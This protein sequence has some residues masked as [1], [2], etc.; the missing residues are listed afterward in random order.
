MSDDT[1][2]L[3]I[4]WID[5]ESKGYIDVF[6]ASIFFNEGTI[7]DY[8]HLVVGPQRGRYLAKCR[9]VVDAVSA[10]LDY[11][12]FPKQNK[13]R[14]MLLGVLRL[15]FE[16]S[17]REKLRAIEWKR[18]GQKI[19]TSGLAEIVNEP[20]KIWAKY[21]RKAADARKVVRKI[22][23]REGAALFRAELMLAYN[24]QCCVSGCAIAA[25]L[26][27]AHIDPFYGKSSDNPQN[28]LLL[29]R[30]LHALFDADLLAVEPNSGVVHIAPEAQ[31]SPEYKVL[32]LRK[33]TLPPSS[34][35]PSRDAL[36]RR[37]FRFKRVNPPVTT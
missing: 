29:R 19:F 25:V 12:A 18:K 14:E 23:E 10:E 30:D 24:E 9:V 26:E 20:Q 4:R 28:G 7:N 16:D 15:K 3:S 21:E 37:W 22:R 5:S 31:I 33:I 1:K 6:R 11:G 36:S 8:V 17:S 34:L 32:H 13:S 35:Q 27:G 2:F